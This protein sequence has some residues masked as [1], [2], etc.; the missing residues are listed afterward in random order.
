VRFIEK[1]K[2]PVDKD[3]L[4]KELEPMRQLF[5]GRHGRGERDYVDPSSPAAKWVRDQVV[6]PEVMNERKGAPHRGGEAVL[7]GVLAHQRGDK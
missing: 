7:A 3:A 6:G 4:A 5:M 2:R 1:A